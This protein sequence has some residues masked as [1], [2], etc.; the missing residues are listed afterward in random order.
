MYGPSICM[1]A[2]AGSS[3]AATDLAHFENVSNEEVM[4]AGRNLVTPVD[5]RA[6]IACRHWSGVQP[7]VLK[8][9]PA[10]PLTCRSKKPGNSTLISW[11]PTDGSRWIVQAQPAVGACNTKRPGCLAANSDQ[12]RILSLPTK[13]LCCSCAF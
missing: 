5:L 13:R 4:S 10:K 9:T 6:R 12:Q 3:Y 8:S 2:M 1:P 11:S 7:G